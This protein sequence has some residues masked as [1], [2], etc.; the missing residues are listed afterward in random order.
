MHRHVFILTLAGAFALVGCG[1]PKTNLDA[2]PYDVQRQYE[3]AGMMEKEGFEQ[4]VEAFNAQDYERA[5]DILRSLNVAGQD[6]AYVLNLQGAAYTKLKNFD[7]ARESFEYALVHAPEFFP[8]RFNLA[9]IEFLQGEYKKA[10]EKFQQLAQSA[11][12]SDLLIFKI[13]LSH[14]MDGDTITARRLLDRM[15]RP[16]TTPVWYYSAA[17]WEF[18]KGNKRSGRN[19]V[20]IA[21]EL[22]PEEKDR[23]LYEETLRDLKW[24]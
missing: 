15:P 14:L 21:R 11:G 8:P 6:K 9:E 7:R 19:Y 18:K 4:A 23:Q 2:L 22:Y 16:G 5:I 20:R 24:L 10:L 13:F 12:V 17:A 1:D 3:Q